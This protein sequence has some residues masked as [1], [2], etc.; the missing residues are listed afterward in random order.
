[1]QWASSSNFWAP[2]AGGHW[3]AFVTDSFESAHSLANDLGDG[4]SASLIDKPKRAKNESMSG[5]LLEHA[6][7]LSRVALFDASRPP[8]KLTLVPTPAGNLHDALLHFSPARYKR[9]A[10]PNRI[11][12][13]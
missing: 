4:S 5:S 6:C 8:P 11:L 12:L 3:R 7:S 9:V 1:M 13:Q 10:Y 2:E